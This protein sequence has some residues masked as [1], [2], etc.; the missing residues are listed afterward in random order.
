MITK[1]DLLSGK[2]FIYQKRAKP[3]YQYRPRDDNGG[4]IVS[5]YNLNDGAGDYDCNVDQITKAGIHLYTSCC[6][7]SVN[8]YIKFSEFNLYE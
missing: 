1:E 8:V 3:I 2:K 4:Y 6:G 7:K 5:L